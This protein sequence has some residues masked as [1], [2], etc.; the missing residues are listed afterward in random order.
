MWSKLG[1]FAKDPRN[2]KWLCLNLSEIEPNLESCISQFMRILPWV[3][4]SK[5]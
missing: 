4:T 2:P 3:N 5:L 1:L